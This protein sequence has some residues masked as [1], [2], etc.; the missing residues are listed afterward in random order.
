MRYVIA[1][2][3]FCFGILVVVLSI[4]RAR[5]PLVT[6]AVDTEVPL[7]QVAAEA[8]A[9]T[10]TS[11]EDVYPL[12]Y[13]GFLPDHP[14]YFLKMIRD[15]VRL[16]L[17]R[18]ALARAD[19]QLQYADKRVTAALALAEKGKIGLAASTAT[20]AEVYFEQAIV[21]A[22]RSEREGQDTSGF[23]ER[24]RLASQKHEQVLVGVRSRMPEETINNLEQAL[25]SQQ[26]VRERTREAVGKEEGVEKVE[27]DQAQP[28][29]SQDS[30]EAEDSG[31]TQ[32]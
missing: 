10:V 24:V 11:D 7:Y 29:D 4:W 21:E 3:A 17:T 1:I 6:L 19:L 13:P 32:E 22:E 14:L 16:W 27:E 30:E 15:R 12:P 8:A 18:D 20:K 28:T 9:E 5:P 25:Q 26:R 31:R 2:G 23:W